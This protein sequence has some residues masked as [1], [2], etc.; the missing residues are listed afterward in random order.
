MDFHRW[1]CYGAR[2]SKQGDKEAA[3][4]LAVAEFV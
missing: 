3:Q 2:A 4:G 1:L